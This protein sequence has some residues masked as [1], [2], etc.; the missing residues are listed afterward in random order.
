[1]RRSSGPNYDRVSEVVLEVPPL[2]E[3]CEDIPLLI[4][5]F[6]TLWSR[7]PGV[8]VRGVMSEAARPSSRPIPGPGT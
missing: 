6:L 7:K 4:D 3:R 2:K 5:H 8:T 1:M